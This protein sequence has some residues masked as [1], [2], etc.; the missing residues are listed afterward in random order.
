M[1]LV[2]RMM[3]PHEY[4]EERF[5]PFREPPFTGDAFDAESLVASD[6]HHVVVL[7][8]AGAFEGPGVEELSKRIDGLRD[9]GEGIFVVNLS[10]VTKVDSMGLGELVRSFVRV[11]RGGGK[12]ALVNPPQ[13][14]RQLVESMKFL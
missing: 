13:H 5:A 9:R 8:L 12:L 6:V 2:E 4:R 10:A 14:F 7:D 11:S 3:T 1:D